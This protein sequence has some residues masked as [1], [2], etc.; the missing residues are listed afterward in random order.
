MEALRKRQAAFGGDAADT[1]LE[2]DNATKRSGYADRSSG[3][4]A[5]AAIAESRGNGGRGAAAG[6]AGNARE[7]PGIAGWTVVRVIGGYA[8]REVVKI[9]LAEK[10]RAR[11]PELGPNLRIVLRNEVLQDFGTGGGANALG[12][13][14]V[15]QRDGNAMKRA[16]VAMTF[17]AA[18][19]EEL[20]FGFF[21]LGQSDFRGD[22]DV[23]VEFRIQLLDSR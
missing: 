15:F 5:D 23:G 10:D 4:R 8:V 3:I 2:A 21:G 12:V 6:A 13:D 18:G 9:G 11:F 20:G 14:V 22:G 16:A 17:A 7:V 1:G 19:G